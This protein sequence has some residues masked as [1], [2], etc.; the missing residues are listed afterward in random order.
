MTPPTAGR[1]PYYRGDLALVHDLGFA[2]H[3]DRCAPGILALL[4]PVRRRRGLVLELGC[5]TGLLTRH[6]V[7]AGHRVLAS[8]ASPA[9]LA[10]ARRAVP[11]AEEI[12]QLVL[13]DDP[14]PR[15]DAVISVGHVLNYL[16]DLDAVR[17]ALVAIAATLEAG[18]VLAID[19]CDLRYGQARR[20]SLDVGRVGDDWAVIS[21]MSIPQPD[22]CV[23]EITTFVRTSEGCWRRD[24][25]RHD[26]VLI[27]TTQVPAL[28]AD[29]GV[30]VVVGTSFGSGELPV[31]LVTVVGV[32]S[33]GPLT[34]EPP[35][36]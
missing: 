33:P 24:D 11:G 35:R 26:N 31:G 29:H 14:L 15:A 3:A 6:L 2:A 9:M 25:E 12:R 21:R 23:R 27:D 36:K 10:R 22:R 19:L 8:D 5:G 18:G 30:E 17:R 4:E 1:E 16:D 13:P 34:G 28:L 32:A 20:T 7:D